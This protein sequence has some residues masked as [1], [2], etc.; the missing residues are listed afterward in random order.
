M[1]KQEIKSI[2]ALHLVILYLMVVCGCNNQRSKTKADAPHP[3]PIRTSPVSPK[4]ELTMDVEKQL[5]EAMSLEEQLSDLID[6]P[7]DEKTEAAIKQLIAQGVNVNAINDAICKVAKDLFEGQ[8]TLSDSPSSRMPWGRSLCWKNADSGPDIERDIFLLLIEA[9]TYFDK[10]DDKALINQIVSSGDVPLIKLLIKKGIDFTRHEDALLS[11]ANSGNEEAFKLI[12][13]FIPDANYHIAENAGVQNTSVLIEAVRSYY[14]IDVKSAAIVKF[15]L[16][17]G[18]NVNYRMTDGF[19]ALTYAVQYTDKDTVK[20]LLQSGV[21]LEKEPKTLV[22][23]AVIGRRDEIVKLLLDQGVTLDEKDEDGE[24]PLHWAAGSL[25]CGWKR[26]ADTSMI[27]LLLQHGANVHAKDNEGR[28]PLISCMFHT[29]SIYIDEEPIL[30]LIQGGADVSIKDNHGKTAMDYLQEI[31]D[32][33]N[34]D[35]TTTTHRVR[36]ILNHP[37]KNIHLVHA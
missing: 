2:V 3:A 15:L 26:C 14:Y 32:L 20:M 27:K 35:T 29:N 28:T 7:Y 1:I 24:S 4:N 10:N 19:S 30:A 8:G 23:H 6:G 16:D 9:G 25:A 34:T 11:A 33:K 21:N 31:E 22:H 12:F 13:S 5:P 18:A 36:E 17:H 37:E